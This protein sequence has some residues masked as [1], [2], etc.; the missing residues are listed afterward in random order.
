MAFLQLGDLA[1]MAAALGTRAIAAGAFVLPFNLRA[2]ELGAHL[3]F[4]MA[5][6]G[7]YYPHTGLVT[8]GKYLTAGILKVDTRRAS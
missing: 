5:K 4:D 7:A 8:S 3:L 1:G 6:A 2:K